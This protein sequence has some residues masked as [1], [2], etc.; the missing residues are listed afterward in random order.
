MALIECAECNNEVSDKAAACP[1]CGA[2]IEQPVSTQTLEKIDNAIQC[3]FCKRYIDS[4]AISCQCGAE[5]GYSDSSSSRVYDDVDFNSL[6][7][8]SKIFL[9]LTGGLMAVCVLTVLLVGESSMGITALAIIGAFILFLPCY[10]SVISALEVRSMR[11][12]GKQ[13]WKAR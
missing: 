8:R 10:A 2:P 3:P 1:K 9:R 7:K 4:T 5:Y 6:A 13:W 11:T 12:N